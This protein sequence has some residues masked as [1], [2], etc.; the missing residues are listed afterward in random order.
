MMMSTRVPIDR[1]E[2]R[3]GSQ[4]NE[5]S[6]SR[7]SSERMVILELSLGLVIPKPLEVGSDQI[8]PLIL[9]FFFFLNGRLDRWLGQGVTVKGLRVSFLAGLGWAGLVESD[10]WFR[11]WSL[12]ATWRVEDA[13][14]WLWWKWMIIRVVGS[15]DD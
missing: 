3:L 6:L 14:G 10:E 9:I 13:A 2:P 11:A 4:P 1:E 5:S 7:Q 8:E 12:Q 15:V